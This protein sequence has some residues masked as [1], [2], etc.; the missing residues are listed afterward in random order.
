MT[1]D[2]PADLGGFGRGKDGN[3]MPHGAFL[4]MS[5]LALQ[6]GIVALLLLTAAVAA[7]QD[8]LSEPQLVDRIV[9]IVDEEAILQSDLD[10]E[11]EFYKLELER[12]G[13]EMAAPEYQI[14]QE[15]LE[16]LVESKLIVAA[17]KQA[18]ISVEAAAIDQGV[19]SKIEQLVEHF[20]SRE[21]LEQELLR[22]GM[23]LAD[24]RERLAA[25]LTDQ[26][27]LHTVIGRYIR[28]NIEVLENEV[29]DYYEAHRDE[30]P[31]SP[32]S[33]TLG[34]ILI[35]LQ[36]SRETLQAVQRKV[37]LALQALQQGQAF[38]EVARTYSEGPN[39]QRGGAI[40]V[41]RRGDLFDQHLE[42]VIFQLEE[43]QYS[44]PV[45]TQRGV[46]IVRVDS[47]DGDA[48]AISQLFFPMEVTQ[49]DIQA[50]Q[51]RAQAAYERLLAGEAF[52]LV[53]SEVSGDPSSAHKG[54]DLGT[55]RLEDLSPQFQEALQDKPAGELTEPL[56][57]PVG[58]YIFLVKERKEGHQLA[59]EEVKEDI[60]SYLE[61][62]A[63]EVELTKYV[64]S[65]RQRY[66]I[67]L[68][69]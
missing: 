45:E 13:Q 68:K 61:A 58:V 1:V 53:A 21:A 39:A 14:R 62:Q 51:Q 67:D 59:F 36:P 30:M 64:E 26:H 9:A 54:G 56:L 66:F 50:A 55:F 20:G 24:Y 33:L 27:Y 25:Q 11:V 15:V 37:A 60:H 63:L 47:I 31:S 10:R 4:R 3:P 28:P 16:R 49:Q 5:S 38:A 57:T 19:D 41:V 29:F 52:D 32:D 44:Q 34:N 65:L 8:V 48:R 22:N 12:A 2:L 35:P 23:T 18:D 46:H 40:G 43:G 7:S 69:R 17:A 6:R 42:D